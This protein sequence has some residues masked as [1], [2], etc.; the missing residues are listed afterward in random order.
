MKPED[1]QISR[2]ARL[3][4]PNQFPA[5]TRQSASVAVPRV[6]VAVRQVIATAP[7]VRRVVR[8]I[9][10]QSQSK[11]LTRP[12]ASAEARKAHA[13]AQQ[14]TALALVAARAAKV[15]RLKQRRLL[16]PAGNNCQP[17]VSK[18]PVLHHSF[19]VEMKESKRPS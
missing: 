15:R 19:H 16:K 14:A 5:Q 10:S 13:L 4:N 12:F 2:P 6:S 7:T 8:V 3:T 1:S 9:I 11:A 17:E 18:Q